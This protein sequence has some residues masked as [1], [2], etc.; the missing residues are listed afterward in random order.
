M[1]WVDYQRI[2]DGCELAGKY[3]ESMRVTEKWQIRVD[4]PATSKA[5]ILAGVTGE[6]GVT[7]GTGHFDLPDLKAME[8]TLAPTGRD[9]MRW[10]LTIVFYAPPRDKDPEK[11]TENGIP[12]DVWERSGGTTS[13]PLFEDINNDPVV[14]AAD[15]PLEGLEREREESS[16]TLTKCYTDDAS[17]D[18]AVLSCSGKIN[19]GAWAGGFSKTWKCYFKSAKKVSTTKL[20]GNDDAGKLEYIES[21]WEFRYDPETWKSKPWDVGF[22]EIVEGEKRVIKTGDGKAVKQPVGLNSDGTALPPG[23]KP[24]VANNEQGFDIYETADF[25]AAFGEPKLIEVA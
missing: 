10:I 21:H 18:A 12:E 2:N 8:F 11:V 6:I 13:V 5:E 20:D 1:A 19:S 14:N 25:G 23:T 15:D 22:M 16:W 7:W 24:K 4:D 17:L 9:G 3:G